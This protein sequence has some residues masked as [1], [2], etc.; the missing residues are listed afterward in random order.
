MAKRD[1]YEVLGVSR[2]ADVQTIKKAYR[3]LARQYHPDANPNDP[4]AAEKFK[5]I[6]EAYSV[7]SDENKRAQYDQFG[8]AAGQSGFDPG[9][10][11]DF[12]G[13]GGFQ[14]PFDDIFDAFF[15]GMGGAG[16]RQRQANRPQRGR[17]IR[18]DLELDFE[19]AVFGTTKTITLTRDEVCPTCS[20]NGAKPGTAPERCQVC[21][22]TGQVRVGRQTVFGQFVTMQTCS[23]CHGRG[24]IIRELCPECRGR[25]TTPRRRNVEVNI[26]AGVDTGNILRLN[27]QGEAGKNGGPAGDLHVE[28]HV[29][30]HPDFERDH[31]DIRYKTKVSMF[32]AA[33]GTEMK[34]PTL[35]KQPETLRIP[36]GTQSGAV[37]TLRGRGIP[38]LRGS[39]RGDYHIEVTVEV[40]RDLSADERKLLRKIAEGRKETVLEDQSILQRMRNAF[41]R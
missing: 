16:G 15:G 13:F 38:R 28:I 29:R 37:F 11:G 2:D 23:N 9:G 6:S 25:G 41:N 24:Q 22:G 20:G 40:P 27:Q 8:H 31:E 10:F 36:P 5:E 14:S 1:Y 34:V 26:P 4:T 35:E 21:G 7:L 19:E 12:G 39:G 17:D 18:V 33:L 3:K 32:Q 30:P